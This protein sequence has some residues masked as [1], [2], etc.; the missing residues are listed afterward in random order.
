MALPH[1]LQ[2]R[3]VA[4]LVVVAALVVAGLAVAAP[5]A[6]GPP[7]DAGQAAQG[8]AQGAGPQYAGDAV[9][10]T[11]HEDV[12]KSY[13]ATAHGRTWLPRSPAAQRGCETCHGPGKA[14]ADAGGDKTKIVVFT[15]LKVQDANAVCTTCHNRGTHM[16]WE[17]SAHENRGVGCLTCHSVHHAK[18]AAAQLTYPTQMQL[19]ARCHRPET[20]KMQRV[21]HMAVRNSPVRDRGFTMECSSCHNP[22]G[23]ANVRLL[24]VGSDVN[25]SCTSC[26]AEKRGPFLWEHE[27][28]TENCLTC[29]DPHGSSNDRMLVAKLPMLCQRCHVTSRHPPTPYD[30]YVLRNTTGSNRIAGRGCVTCHQQIHGSNSTSGDAFIR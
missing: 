2:R 6:A 13:H 29:H 25:E 18:S 30:L 4:F 8:A 27:P 12:G 5:A 26:H 24:K 9:C 20:Q 14:H 15:A 10:L 11:C 23:S 3:Y 22:H 16:L 7:R 17:T 1:V 28:V 19:C 21:S